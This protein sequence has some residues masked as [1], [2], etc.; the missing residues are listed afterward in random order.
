M[1]G[2]LKN[3]ESFE[4][5]KI[6]KLLDLI[7]KEDKLC[8]DVL[9]RRIKELVRISSSYEQYINDMNLIKE[10]AQK[11]INDN[12]LEDALNVFLSAYQTFKYVDL[13]YYAGK[14]CYLLGDINSSIE[15]FRRYIMFGGYLKLDKV[16]YYLSLSYKDKNYESERFLNLSKR[17]N[18]L[19]GKHYYDFK[20]NH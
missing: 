15:Y 11:L 18:D 6:V 16:Y 17:Y 2:I 13:L 8:Q 12:Y 1:Y 5:Y 14:T 20:Y 3:I 19:Y 4:Y 7:G 9:D 10:T